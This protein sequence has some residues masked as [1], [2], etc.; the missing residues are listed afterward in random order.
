ANKAFYTTTLELW[1]KGVPYNPIAGFSPGMPYFCL[2]V[3]TGGGKTWLAAKA[4]SLVNTHL[5]RSEHSLI[6]WL[7]SSN[8]IREQTLKALKERQHPYHEALREVGPITVLDLDEAKNV[9]RATLDT[10]TTI[11]VTTRQ[12]FQVGNTEIRKVYESSGTLMHHFDSI[13]SEQKAKLIEDNGVMPYSLTN[14]LRLRRPFVIVDEAHNSRTE[15]SFETL[16]RF[17]PSGIMELTATPDTQKNPSNVLHS[18]YAAELKGEQ[19]IKLPIRLETEPNWQ[20]CLADAIARRNELQTL[21]EREQRTGAA[22]LRPIV[23]IQAQA[24]SKNRDTLHVDRVRD[25]LT[26]NHRIPNE[27]ILI[28]TGDEKGLEQIAADHQDGILSSD[29]PVKFVITQQALAE[30][31]DCPFAYILV[32]MAEVRSSTAVEQLLG[33]VLRQPGAKYRSHEALN[34]SYAF[35]VSNDF[36]ATAE[37]LR[38]RLV[39][40]AGFERKEAAE[41]VTAEKPEQH[42]LDLRHSLHSAVVRPVVVELLE[43]PQFTHIAKPVRDKIQ[44]DALTKTLT[45]TEPLSLEDMAE[46]KTAVSSPEAV[47]AIEQAAIAS[48]TTAVEF[49]RSP[50]EQGISFTVPQLAL[51]VQGQLQLF[52]DTDLLDYPWDISLYD[53]QPNHDELTRLNAIE[54]IASTGELDIEEKSGRMKARFM[55]DLQRDLGL[56]Y[57]PEHWDDV[58][59]AA[60]L[61]RNLPDESLTHDSKRAFV[62]AWLTHLLNKPNIDLSKANQYKFEIR[63]LLETRIQVMRQSAVQKAYQATLFSDDAS[64]HVTVSDDCPFTFNPYAYAPTRDYAGEYGPYDFRRHYYSRIGDFDSKEEF[65]CAAYL[66]QQAEKGRLKFWV[67]NLVRREGS[68]F[69]LQKADGKFY[70][71]FICKLPDN[72]NLIV[73]YKGANLWDTPKAKMDRMVGQLWADMSNE[74]CRFVMVKERNWSTIDAMLS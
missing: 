7:V 12:A 6:L 28:A 5:L 25:E 39:Q 54:R 26:K 32:S 62:A 73:E 24:R 50:A 16:S 59:L 23:L 33:R 68:S 53:T 37:G 9:T 44:W 57:V 43:I 35:V 49:F 19:M 27:E 66:D 64:E 34:R 69:S 17:R 22:Y 4:V 47:S 61:C 8:A 18:V 30:G 15:L 55:P 71:D 67:R 11:I 74:K 45:I 58:K 42:S 29:C 70:P 72:S 20:Q 41:F 48:R 63:N 38:D 2:R 60:W 14:V 51:W 13:T 36:N 3:P 40:G 65:E 31:W 46:V 10:S 21:A 52:D 56:T 1:G